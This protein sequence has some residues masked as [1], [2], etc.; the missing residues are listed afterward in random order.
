MGAYPVEAVWHTWDDEGNPY[1]VVDLT[2]GAALATTPSAGG[3]P[4]QA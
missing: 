1:A 2:T 4:K 3:T